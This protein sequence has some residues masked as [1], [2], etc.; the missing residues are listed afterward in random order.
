VRAIVGLAVAILFAI[1]G[2]LTHAQNGNWRAYSPPHSGFSIETPAPLRRVMSFE[3]EH[4][5]SL[6]PDQ[7]NEWAYCYAAIE[8]TPQDSRFGIA[9][10]NGRSRITRSQK[11]EELLEYLSWIFFADDDELQFMRA[12]VVVRNKGLTGKEYFY[13]DTY[14]SGNLFTRGR[15]FDT[16]NKIYVIVFVGQ[17]IKDLT[18][19]DAERFLNSFRLRRRASRT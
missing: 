10:I 6:A 19:P 3:G 7:R 14:G 1:Q 16:G 8:T 9:V 18:S 4:G 12:P 15:I 13:I 2:D 5:A 17:N 11:R